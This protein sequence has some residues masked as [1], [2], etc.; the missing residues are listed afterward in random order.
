[1]KKLLILIPVLA[2]FTSCE[3]GMKVTT[4]FDRAVDFTQYK[5]FQLLPWND[6]LN[7]LMQKNTR[8]LIEDAI[9]EQ[10]IKKGYT[11]VESGA[12]IVLSLFVHVDEKTGTTAYN[13]Y[14]GGYG[15]YGYHGG[16][17]YGAGYGTTTYQNYTYQVGS[18]IIDVYDQKE[19]KLVWQGIGS[20]RLSDNQKKNQ[21][22]IDSYVRQVLYDY[23]SQGKAKK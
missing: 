4:D 11:Y 9:K 10:M 21:A 12:D 17:G 1:M 15:G 22:R 8:L 2:L 3:S 16:F 13:T 5:T 14:V 20:D 18:L 7:D 23:P 19:R 6:E